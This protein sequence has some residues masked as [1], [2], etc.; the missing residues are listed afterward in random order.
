MGVVFVLTTIH[1]PKSLGTMFIFKYI[2]ISEVKGLRQNI[3]SFSLPCVTI[4]FLCLHQPVS[5]SDTVKGLSQTLN[6]PP[7][8]CVCLLL[9]PHSPWEAFGIWVSKWFLQNLFAQVHLIL[10]A[11]ARSCITAVIPLLPDINILRQFLCLIKCLQTLQV[12]WFMPGK[13]PTANP[14]PAPFPGTFLK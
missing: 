13:S 8:G 1:F 5:K 9:G 3:N 6:F 14:C 12:V 10:L 11:L 4:F 2:E 7:E